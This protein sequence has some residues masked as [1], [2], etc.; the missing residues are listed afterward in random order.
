M[1]LFN[2]TTNNPLS[3]FI[4]FQPLAYGSAT[5]PYPPQTKQL[6]DIMGFF[7]TVGAALG[8][9]VLQGSGNGLYTFCQSTR[10]VD[11]VSPQLVANQGLPDATSQ[12]IGRDALCRIYLGDAG[13]T[14]VDADDALFCP[15]GC[16]P[17]TIYRQFSTPK[18]VQWNAQMPVGSS[19]QFIVYDDTGAPLEQTGPFAG[20]TVY[21]DWSMTILATEN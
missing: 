19:I 21:S 3:N 11:I 20:G 10:Y 4:A 6:F 13:Q 18:Y 1:P 12:T 7:S 15:P 2:Y 9:D 8:N 5:Y 16:R 17:T 14:V